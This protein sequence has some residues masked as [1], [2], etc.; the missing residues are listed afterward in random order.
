MILVKCMLR[1]DVKLNVIP[2]KE[3]PCPATVRMISVV[4]G[5]SSV[6]LQSMVKFC[7]TGDT[8]VESLLP[9]CSCGTPTGYLQ[10]SPLS[11]I[12]LS[13]AMSGMCSST[14]IVVIY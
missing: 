6:M 8:T 1:L 7:P 10:Q 13:N 9:G 14:K 5:Q 4:K 11:K 2:F 12:D 3:F